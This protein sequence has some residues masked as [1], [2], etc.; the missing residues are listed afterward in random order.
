MIIKIL[1][2]LAFILFISC[3]K[4]DKYVFINDQLLNGS[5]E[6]YDMPK[7]WKYR[8]GASLI[9]F[10]NKLYLLGGWTY[11]EP[12]TGGTICNEIWES[13]DGYTWERLPDAPWPGRHGMGAVVHNGKL[14][15]LGGDELKDCWSTT[16]C[17]DWVCE[18]N[19][20][21]F[22]GR[23]TPNLASLAG[24]LILYGG[25]KFLS[26]NCPAPASC[27][28]VGFDDVWSSKD[29]KNW[30]KISTAPWRPRGLVHNSV[31]FENKIYLI[32]GGLKQSHST[33]AVAETN[34]ESADVWS[35]FDGMNWLLESSSFSITP[36]THFSVL[37]AFGAIWI[38]DGSISTQANVSND[39][40]FSRDGINYFR[41]PVPV[42]M[43]KRHAS[44]F[45]NFK[46]KLII[47]GG[48]PTDF[49]RRKV[50]VYKIL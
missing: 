31:V 25:V 44:S 16:N 23:Y 21:P 34:F 19:N 6:V 49:P 42:D 22:E 11:E 37:S 1:R 9:Q 47:L 50:Y 4:E 24:S 17:V 39:L 3:T 36:R 46:N 35:S 26:G 28:C 20:L 41:V 33:I 8:D 12:Y 10:N 13:K 14:Y 48:P 18:N 45:V 5:W 27:T 32:G 40:F 29:G 30:K 7:N 15:I 43:P 2:I 38:S